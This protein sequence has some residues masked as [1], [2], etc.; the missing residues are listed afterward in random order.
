MNKKKKKKLTKIFS[1]PLLSET[2]AAHSKGRFERVF[3]LSIRNSDTKKQTSLS[4]VEQTHPKKQVKNAHLDVLIVRVR[5]RV[6]NVASHIGIPQMNESQTRRRAHLSSFLVLVN[7][8]VSILNFDPCQCFL[9]LS[10]FHRSHL[11]PRVCQFQ[12]RS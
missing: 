6:E 2:F 10:F 1:L 4:R 5:K 11:L 7:P 12:I 8:L 9:Q 3:H